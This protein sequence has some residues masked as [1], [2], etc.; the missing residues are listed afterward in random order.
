M[1]IDIRNKKTTLEDKASIYTRRNDDM[2]EKE[3]IRNMSAKERRTHFTTYYLP[4]LA[5]IV[6]IIAVI[7]YIVW[8]DFI[9]K[10]DVYMRCAILNESITDSSLTEMSDHFT[11]SMNMDIGKNKASFY[12]YYTRSDVAMQFGNNTGDDLSEITSRLVANM[13]DTMIASPEDVEQSYLKKGFITDLSTFLTKEEYSRL[14]DYL[15]I[16]ETAE[17]NNGKA[18]GIRLAESPV[19]QELFSDRTALQQDPVL[20]II[21][22]ATDEGK[23]YARKFIY[24]LFPKVFQQ[25]GV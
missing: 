5:V 7:F 13:L 8:T 17:Y 10:A 2:S 14:Q 4:K 11:E 12:L 25:K 15:Y 23:E 1:A 9:N 22:N 18:Y 21:S 16:P 24:F 3:R 20:F 6:T 19:Y